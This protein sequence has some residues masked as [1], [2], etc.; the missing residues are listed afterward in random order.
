[1]GTMNIGEVLFY[2]ILKYYWLLADFM[3]LDLGHLRG[4]IS[5]VWC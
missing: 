4:K 1:M 3:N 5:E 2:M